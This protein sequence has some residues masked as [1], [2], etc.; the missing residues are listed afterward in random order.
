M[1]REGSQ[2]KE[3]VD[4]CMRFIDEHLYEKITLK[5]ISESM[6]F[7]ET[8]ISRVFRKE[9]GMTVTDYIRAV[10]VRAAQD[11]MLGGNASYSEIAY[12]L[13]FC[14]QSHFIYVFRKETHMTPKS[15]RLSQKGEVA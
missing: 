10:K 13:G 1:N 3:I 4:S 2:A 11:M 12:T 6:Y 8:H 7:S 15:Y 5:E 14:S 9:L